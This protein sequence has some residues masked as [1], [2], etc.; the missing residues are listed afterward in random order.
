MTLN[1]LKPLPQN[2]K[3]SNFLAIWDYS[4]Q[5][6]TVMNCAEITENKPKPYLHMNLFTIKRE[7]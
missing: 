1:D 4:A 5:C 6:N 3:F 7:F 2:R